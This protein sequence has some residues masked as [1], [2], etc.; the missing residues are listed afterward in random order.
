MYIS[1]LSKDIQPNFF[2]TK[3][4]CFHWKPKEFSK[5]SLFQQIS[6]IKKTYPLY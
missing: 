4:F 5:E 1:L 6:R 3:L 2:L